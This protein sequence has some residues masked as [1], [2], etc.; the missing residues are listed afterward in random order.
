[1]YAN[2]IAIKYFQNIQE[3]TLNSVTEEFIL[4]IT[5]NCQLIEKLISKLFENLSINRNI[6]EFSLLMN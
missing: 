3:L 4:K 2:S 1:M 5:Q 6:Y